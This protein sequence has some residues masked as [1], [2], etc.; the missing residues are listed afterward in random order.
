MAT[1]SKR[2]GGQAGEWSG[3]PVR[4]RHVREEA[5]EDVGNDEAADGDGGSRSNVELWHAGL[6]LKPL[7]QRWKRRHAQKRVQGAGSKR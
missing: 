4:A 7:E 2:A 6:A 3:V 5:G 1:V